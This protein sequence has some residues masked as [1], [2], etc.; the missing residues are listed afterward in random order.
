MKTVGTSALSVY[1]NH[2]KRTLLKTIDYND[3]TNIHHINVYLK[4]SGYRV[5]AKSLYGELMVFANRTT[6]DRIII[7]LIKKCFRLYSNKKNITVPY[8]I[9]DIYIYR[10]GKKLMFTNEPAL[11]NNHSFYYVRKGTK[12]M[13]LSYKKEYKIYLQERLDILSKE[14][15][16]DLTGWKLTIGEYSSFFGEC[17]YGSRRFKFDYRTYAY[18][19]DIIDSLVYHELTHVY[20]HGHSEKFYR[21]LRHYCPD[22]DRLA[23]LLDG[24]Y[25]EGDM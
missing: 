13:T 18:R 22:Y 20:E 21:I 17:N 19:P 14:M 24:N 7:E 6:P 12:D 10:L 8:K 23:R 5:T 15:G 25:F 3:G 2:V 11:K 4:K 1:N 16:L 9:D